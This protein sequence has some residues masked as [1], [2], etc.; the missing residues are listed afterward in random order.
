[1]VQ[2]AGHEIEADGMD[3]KPISMTPQQEEDVLS[4]VWL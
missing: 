3:E 4:A 1:M 2:Q